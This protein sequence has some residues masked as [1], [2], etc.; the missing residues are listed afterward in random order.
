[1]LVVEVGREHVVV[2]TEEDWEV[3]GQRRGEGGVVAAGERNEKKRNMKKR[4]R[5]RKKMA[6]KTR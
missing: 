6:S 5:K 2:L 3:V 1:M 4:K